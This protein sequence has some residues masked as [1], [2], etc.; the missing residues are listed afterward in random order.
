[1]DKIDQAAKTASWLL[2]TAVSLL[3]ILASCY[4]GWIIACLF[5]TWCGPPDSLGQ[6]TC[7][8]V[9]QDTPAV[10]QVGARIGRLDPV[11][12]HMRQG[13]LDHLPGMV[14]LQPFGNTGHGPVPRR[15]G[16]ESEQETGS[17][18]DGGMIEDFPPLGVKQMPPY[19]CHPFRR[20]GVT[21][22][23]DMILTTTTLISQRAEPTPLW[24][25]LSRNAASDAGWHGFLATVAEKR[26]EAAPRVSPLARAQRRAAREGCWW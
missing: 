15:C 18:N 20:G 5:L 1:M 25:G 6:V 16:D 3:P 11:A 26:S 2:S 22:K 24:S 10:E 19:G 13:R 21:W 14:R 9:H 4:A 23:G 17:P 8:V 7:P 12:D